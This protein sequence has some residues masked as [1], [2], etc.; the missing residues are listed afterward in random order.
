MKVYSIHA[1]RFGDRERHSYSVG[2]CSTRD[3][4]LKMAAD[5]EEWRG[6]KYE[7]EVCEFELDSPTHLTSRNTVNIIKKI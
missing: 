6:G 1:Y 3:A 5:E 2:V 4:A 7:C